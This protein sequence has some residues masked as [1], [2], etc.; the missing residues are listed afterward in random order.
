MEV[1]PEIGIQTIILVDIVQI[2][3]LS[4]ASGRA[5][6]DKKTPQLQHTLESHPYVLT[7]RGHRVGCQASFFL[8]ASNIYISPASGVI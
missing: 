3:Q 2:Y 6:H 1:M 5:P 4:L 8:K 7:V